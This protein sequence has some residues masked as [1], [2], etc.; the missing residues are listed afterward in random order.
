[1]APMKNPS[2]E[3]YFGGRFLFRTKSDYNTVPSFN[4]LEHFNIRGLH[5][6]L[7]PTGTQVL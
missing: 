3:Q 7:F 1:M 5:S 6:L 2:G 4:I